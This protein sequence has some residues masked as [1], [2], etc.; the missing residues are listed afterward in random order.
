MSWGY[1][2]LILLAGNPGARRATLLL[3]ELAGSLQPVSSWRS[4]FKE[5][6][7]AL[8]RHRGAERHRAG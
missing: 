6:T 7:R 3:A 2:V 8:A 4:R 5:V 1:S